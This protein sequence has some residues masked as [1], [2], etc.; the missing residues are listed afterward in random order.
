MGG[1]YP[2]HLP[3]CDCASYKIA[4][5]GPGTSTIRE[6]K[7]KNSSRSSFLDIRFGVPQ[8]SLIGPLLFLELVADLPARIADSISI[9][10]RG[11]KDSG[12]EVGLAA[13]TDD[14]LCLAMGK[15]MEKMQVAGQVYRSAPQ[16]VS[17][18]QDK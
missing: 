9:D 1:A 15:G 8:G 18:S 16:M 11:I 10:N 2:P 12:V 13:Y 4:F 5:Q 3:M 17:Q 6:S 7:C 14:A